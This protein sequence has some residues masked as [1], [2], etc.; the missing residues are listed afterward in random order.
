MNLNICYSQFERKN[1][2]RCTLFLRNRMQRI[3]SHSRAYDWNFVTTKANPADK[4]TQGLNA[5]LLVKDKCCFE[6]P[7]FLKLSPDKWPALP[8][9]LPPSKVLNCFESQKGP[10]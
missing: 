3:L 2:K 7:E 8:L 5:K 10:H 4:L 6:G 9:N 1:V